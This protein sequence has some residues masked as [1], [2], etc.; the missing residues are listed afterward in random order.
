MHERRCARCGPVTKS[1][2]LR[3]RRVHPIQDQIQDP[4]QDQIQDPI[5]DLIQD[6]IQDH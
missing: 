6:P 1:T 4:I 2:I 3:R 5:L